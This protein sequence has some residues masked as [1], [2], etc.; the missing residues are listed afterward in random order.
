[1]AAMEAHAVTV[2]RVKRPRSTVPL[3]QVYVTLP[4]SKRPRLS[5]LSLASPSL[6]FRR[7][8]TPPPQ[9]A[10]SAPHVTV[11]D[12]DEHTIRLA[13]KRPHPE[14]HH[15]TA[16]VVKVPRVAEPSSPTLWT[17]NG[18]VMDRVNVE[19]DLFVRD[20]ECARLGVEPTSH[21]EGGDRDIAVVEAA[22][23][24]MFVVESESDSDHQ[25]SDGEENSVD[26][27]STPHTSEGAS[28]RSSDDDDDGF[29]RRLGF[30]PIDAGREED[31]DE[32]GEH[33]RTTRV[34]GW[35][36]G[37]RAAHQ[38]DD[39]YHEAYEPDEHSDDYFDI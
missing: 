36:I 30:A 16:A 1:M 28:D 25:E 23:L 17:C 18:H 7:L 10:L 29:G 32:Y 13:R 39:L 11:I 27:P 20:D 14:T 2:L 6:T 5:S 22:H 21:S 26:Y 19:I 15:S 38:K 34:D 31:D 12:V 35:K 4:P 33:H 37:V 8:Q 24:P 3:S 9:S